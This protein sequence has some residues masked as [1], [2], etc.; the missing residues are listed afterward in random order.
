MNQ[1]RD[2]D[3]DQICSGIVIGLGTLCDQFRFEVGRE[4]N[5]RTDVNTFALFSAR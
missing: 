2:P 5:F 3:A 4:R 1:Q